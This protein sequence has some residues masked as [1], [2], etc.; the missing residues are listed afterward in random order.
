MTAP[1]KTERKPRMNQGFSVFNLH[2]NDAGDRADAEF[3][4]QFSQKA[5]DEEI[6]PRHDAG[7]MTIFHTEM[8]FYEWAWV[9]LV[10]AYVNENRS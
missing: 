1:T 6:K 4:R 7:I 8:S 10:T 3:V 2:V 9:S 5:F